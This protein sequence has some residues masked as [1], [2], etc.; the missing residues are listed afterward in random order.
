VAWSAPPAPAGSRRAAARVLL[1]ELLAGPD[2]PLQRQLV[3]EQGLVR[4]LWVAP[5][6]DAVVVLAEIEPDAHPG[7]VHAAVEQAAQA[8]VDGSAAELPTR[9]D[10]ARAHLARQSVLR[11]EQPGDWASLVAE[12]VSAGAPAAAVDRHA[13]LVQEI[14]LDEVQALAAEL[15]RPEFLREVVLTPT[16]E[17]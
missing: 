3:Q 9:L 8:L 6:T 4:R 11:L 12:A 7:A 2:A 15:L 14:G 5:R 16:E 17:R 1:T 13:D 10:A